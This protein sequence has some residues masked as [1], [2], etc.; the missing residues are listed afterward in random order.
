MTGFQIHVDAAA[1]PLAQLCTGTSQ[2]NYVVLQPIDRFSVLAGPTGCLGGALLRCAGQK[3]K[4]KQKS[5]AGDGSAPQA[6]A[7][8]RT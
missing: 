3:K 5:L 6:R 7:T 2:R 4:I 1:T 8:W